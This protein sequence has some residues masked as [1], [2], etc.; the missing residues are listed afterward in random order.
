MFTIF[1]PF[2]SNE[3]A[4]E[5]KKFYFRYCEEKKLLKKKLKSVAFFL[6]HPYLKIDTNW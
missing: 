5:L 1:I 6:L 4:I 3:F 2:L